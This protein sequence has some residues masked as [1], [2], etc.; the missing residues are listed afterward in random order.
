[1]PLEQSP[2]S[3]QPRM[4]E[5]SLKIL[6]QLRK[7]IFKPVLKLRPAREVHWQSYGKMIGILERGQT[8]LTVDLPRIIEQE[9][10]DKITDEQWNKIQ[11]KE[12]LRSHVVKILKRSVLDNEPLDGLVEEVMKRW[13]ESL[14]KHR[15]F[16]FACAAQQSAKNYARFLKGLSQ[17]Y[18]LFMDETGDFCGDR[19]RTEIYKELLSSQ[20]EI[21]KMRRMLPARNDGDLYNH[22]K[23]WYKFP[24]PEKK[25][26]KWLRDV[27]DDICLSIKGGP[28]RPQKF[29]SSGKAA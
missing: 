6:D 12:Q 4:S 24:A 11:P 2:A 15:Q 26:R 1:M 27:C 13:V 23:P 29:S 17:G 7:T 8:F 10:L 28:G 22:L 9:G 19:G 18:N 3:D 20:Y 14:E 16:A 21:E 5:W 25:A